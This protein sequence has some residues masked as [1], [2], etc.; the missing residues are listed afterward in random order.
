MRKNYV[1]IISFAFFFIIS[2]IISAQSGIFDAYV[3][4]D[5]GFGNNYY[6]LNPGTDTP[7]FDFNGTNLGSFN[8][9]DTFVLNGGQNDVFKCGHDITSGWLNYSIYPTSG[10]A[11]GVFIG[12]DLSNTVNDFPGAACAGAGDN[13]EWITNNAG[14]NILQ[15]LT[16]GVQY[17]I[18]V[19]TLADYSIGGIGQPAHIDND[20]GNNYFATFMFDNPP[21]AVCQD[22][23]VQLDGTGNATITPAQID[24]VSTDDFG[25]A[26]YSLDITNFTCTDIGSKTV[27]LTVTDTIGQTDTCTATVTV[28]D[29]EAPTFITCISRNRDANIGLCTRNI[30]N[31]LFPTFSDNCGITLQTWSTIGATTLSSPGTGIHDFESS[32]SGQIFN[33]GVTIVTVHIEDAAGNSPADCVFTVTINDTQNPSITCAGDINVNVDSGTCTY[34]STN[35]TAPSGADNCSVSSVVASPVS[36]VLGL[37]VVTWTVTDGAGLT[38]TCNQNV[39]VIDNIN[40]SITCAGD[41]NVNVDSGTCTYDSTN[42]TAPSGADNCSVSSVVASPVSLVLG[43]NVVT[44]TVTDG[45]GLTATCNQNVTVIDNINPSITCAGDIN[46]NVDS[47]TC[48]YDSTNLTA[49]SGADNCS[50]SSVVA[51]P[52][53]LV[54]GLNVV[55]WT[56]TDG[57]GLIAT[58]NQ[59]VT[60][61]DNINPSITCAGDI[62]VNVD[63]GTCTYDSTNLTAPSG[64]DNCSVS[65]VVASPV[66]LVLGLNVVTWTVTDGAG[67]TATCNQNV[68]VI[69]NINPSITCA[70]DINVN[71]DSGTCTYDSTNLTAPSGADNCSVS[72]VVASPVSLVLGLNVV[73][74]TVTD[75][76]GLIATCNQ[77]VTVIDN[78]NPSITCAGDI[79]VNV[80]S[81]TCTYDST[82]LTAPSGADNCSVSSVVASPVSLVLGLNVVTWTVTDGAGLTATCNQNVT[83]IDNINPSITCAGDINVNVDSGTCTYDSTNLTAP[84]GA[85]NCSVSSVVAS[86]VSLVLG[87]NVVT[88]TVTD[89]AGLIA[90]CNQNVTVID[91]INPIALCIDITIPLISVPP[92]NLGIATASIVPGDIDNGSSDNCGIAS[93][94]LDKT[95]FDCN[96]IGD[97]TVQLTVTDINGNSSTCNAT[98]T[99]TDASPSASVF[100]SASETFFCDG[101]TS[102]FTAVPGGTYGT[103]VYQW[104]VNG[105]NVGT[106][107]NTYTHPA[108][109]TP[110]VNG[111][112]VTV[113]MTSNLFAC[114]VVSNPITITTNPTVPVSVTIQ[115]IC[116]HSMSRSISNFFRK[117]NY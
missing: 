31:G 112:I 97:N 71:V 55:T 66:S 110:L 103:P 12:I 68:T 90:T 9:T 114:G 89:G 105:G 94:V 10:G 57:A 45:A 14:I 96:D 76:A 115:S 53:S 100:I 95:T 47:G 16:S 56:V 24:N 63:S 83:V 108:L 85:D 50:V 28:Q 23:T 8:S 3:I 117:Y 113:I 49:P 78:I 19:Y 107:S 51:S 104:Q 36:L 65:S 80:D 5:S 41:I 77:N 93:L 109:P 40:P 21:T 38:A 64:A 33:V 70:G 74:W 84:S 26:S 67:L 75:G 4:I 1:A 60:V 46:V 44:W 7:N 82:N 2:N 32:G 6:D 39:T 116:Y 92:S 18:E 99:V 102:T 59:N 87:L 27:T 88:W 15:G 58:C 73:T 11:T 43:L 81:G 98:V 17:T 62:N 37:N 48:T 22:I 111:D 52:V 79:N 13:Q 20:G 54:L 72:S 34:D 29:T 86:P 101:G 91:N 30:Y 42:L 106:N 69:D 61:I 25:I 35:L